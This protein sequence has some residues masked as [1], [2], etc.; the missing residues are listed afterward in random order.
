M[1]L[2]NLFA[3]GAFTAFLF[4]GSAF[5]H[6]NQITKISTD[7][8]S[9]NN[10]FAVLELFTSEGCSSCPPADELMGQLEEKYKDQPVY[11]LSY[12]VDYWNRL[13]W[14][15]RFSS[16][17][18]SQRQ[19]LYSRTLRSQTYTPQLVVNGT[20]EFVGSD[21]KATENA[22]ESVLLDSKNTDI[23]LSA[24]VS[25]KT[26]SV[27][28]K[29]TEADPQSKLLI[30]LV[31]KKSS[32]Q[33]SGGENEGHHLKHYQIVHKQEQIPLKDHPEGTTDFKL[34]ENF[35]IKNWEII[36]FIQNIKTGKI[37]GAAKTEI[38]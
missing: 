28:Y 33:V 29:T 23:N 21:R 30:S 22:I 8:S 5:L 1:I 12:H 27:T 20:T 7:V 16:A 10:G 32:T 3:V 13:G 4:A 24:T 11:I 38:Q 9:G 15:D 26:I 19:Q 2:R 18:N 25:S 35:S 17:E 6:E 34:P 37:S 36:A 31:E 14:K